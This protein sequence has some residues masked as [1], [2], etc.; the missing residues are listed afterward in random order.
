MKI[1]PTALADIV[2]VTPPRFGDR[3]GYFSESWNREKLV[4]AGIVTDFCQDNIS[5]SRP[6]GTVRGL[7]FQRPPFAQDK[8]VSVLSGRILDIAVD[9]RAGSP[10]FGRHVAVELSAEAGNQLYVPQGFAHGFCTLEP[11]TMVFYKVSAP[12]APE[13]DSGLLWNDP[14]LAI[15]WPVDD[16]QAV[17]SDKDRALPRLQDFQTP[18]RY[19]K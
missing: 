4:K 9:L 5:V 19:G 7:H 1:E 14:D 11:D 8:L 2:I 18:F 16:S 6:V 13:H 12:Y 15:D 10:D 17:L 3:R